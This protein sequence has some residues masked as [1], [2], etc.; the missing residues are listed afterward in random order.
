LE[1]GA[2]RHPGQNGVR[3]ALSINFRKVSIENAPPSLWSPDHTAEAMGIPALLLLAFYSVRA[4]KV[5]TICSD[6]NSKV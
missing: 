4:P 3:G 6:K 5:T 1:T 2:K